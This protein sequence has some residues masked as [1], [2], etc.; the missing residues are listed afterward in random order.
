MASTTSFLVFACFL[1]VST[2]VNAN[3]PPPE[4]SS[5][6]TPPVYVSP[7]SPPAP[8][9]APADSPIYF[10]PEAPVAYSPSYFPDP[11]APAYSP[12]YYP[13]PWGPAS[14]PVQEPT[15][16]QTPSV[17]YNHGFCVVECMQRCKSLEEYKGRTR[18]CVRVC[19][20]C[21]KANNNCVPGPLTKCS[22]WDTIIY[23]DLTVKCP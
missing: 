20:H 2:Q 18:V 4:S 1:L 10:Y 14:S 15:P 16:P 8:P 5:P 13:D 23:H 6:D 22:S 17:P 19:S 7:E 11:E 3:C 21:C 12:I 9:L